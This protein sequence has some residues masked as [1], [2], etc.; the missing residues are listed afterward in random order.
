MSADPPS[1]RLL[2]ANLQR[3]RLSQRTLDEASMEVL[4]HLDALIDKGAQ[5]SQVARTELEAII[6]ICL[7]LAGSLNGE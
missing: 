5:D 1:L 3:G 7:H 2:H 6:A 4:K